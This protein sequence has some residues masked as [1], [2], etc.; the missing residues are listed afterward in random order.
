MVACAG[1]T[2]MDLLVMETIKLTRSSTLP[3]NRQDI[4]KF[5]SIALVKKE[6]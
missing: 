1:T 5:S 6:E 2:P 3:R 4:R